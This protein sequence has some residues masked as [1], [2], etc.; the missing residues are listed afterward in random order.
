MLVLYL[1]SLLL[2]S[3]LFSP[4]N[5]NYISTYISC[6]LL[7]VFTSYYPIYLNV[8]LTLFGTNYRGTASTLISNF[9]RGIIE[10][11]NLLLVL[12]LQNYLHLNIHLSTYLLT[13]FLFL[14][15][16]IALYNI[17]EPYGKNLDFVE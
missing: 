7:G 1:G 12:F 15:S 8:V 9:N 13:V 5:H 17:P 2:I 11:L 6:F 10:P 14:L 3:F 16:F 4:F